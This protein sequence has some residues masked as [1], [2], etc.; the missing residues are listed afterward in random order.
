MKPIVQSGICKLLSDIF[1]IKNGSK[2]VM[3]YR[4]CFSSFFRIC[5]LKVRVN[6]EGLKLNDTHRILVYADD[7]NIL[8]GRMLTL[9]KNTEDLVVASKETGLEVNSDEAK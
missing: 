4:Y 3:L 9:R 8:G 5:H 6:Q 7:V 1:P 2:S